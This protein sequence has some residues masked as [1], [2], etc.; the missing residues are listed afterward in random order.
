VRRGFA[1]LRA[2]LQRLADGEELAEVVRD[3]Y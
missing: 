1:H 2:Q 3:G